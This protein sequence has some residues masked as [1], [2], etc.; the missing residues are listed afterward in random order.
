MNTKNQ[1]GSTISNPPARSTR[2][3]RKHWLNIH[4][5]GMFVCDIWC[6][7]LCCI[8]EMVSMAVS[9][10]C[11]SKSQLETDRRRYHNTTSDCSAKSSADVLRACSVCVNVVFYLTEV[12]F[13]CVVSHMCHVYVCVYVMWINNV[14]EIKSTSWMHWLECDELRH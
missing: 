5:L 4:V 2:C 9:R 1:E 10:L 6:L 14:F 13:L 11:Y 3:H 7:C 12:W 8:L